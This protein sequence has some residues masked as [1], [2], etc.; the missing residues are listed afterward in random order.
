MHF[1]L[2][3]S[4]YAVIFCKALQQQNVVGGHFKA[5]FCTSYLLSIVEVTTY[6]WIIATGF[7]SIP[8]VGTGA[9][10]GVITAMWLHRKVFDK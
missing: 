2:M 4:T 10:F 9:A 5:A 1:G 6:I 7:S 3:L 8:W